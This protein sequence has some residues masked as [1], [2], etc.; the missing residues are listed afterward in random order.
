MNDSNLVAQHVI[1][2]HPVALSESMQE[3]LNPLITVIGDSWGFLNETTNLV[4]AFKQ[5][6]EFFKNFIALVASDYINDQDTTD[7][8]T[9]ENF[10]TEIVQGKKLEDAIV[11]IYETMTSG[12]L[13]NI[14]FTLRD[15][16]LK[17]DQ[18]IKH[19]FTKIELD[20]NILELLT[21]F[22][23]FRSSKSTNNVILTYQCKTASRMSM[24]SW[25][26]MKSE[27]LR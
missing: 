9:I 7:Q 16:L 23:F 11:W 10:A 15:Y 1:G 27:G 12:G 13:N 20:W 3:A 2:N 14:F 5:S 18:V 25:L 26:S 17:F 24:I 6:D 4:D 22:L 21:G 19:L 8:E